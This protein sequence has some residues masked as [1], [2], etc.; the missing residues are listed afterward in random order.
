MRK[1]LEIENIE[2]MRRKEGIDDVELHLEIL[3]L[4][5]GDFVKVSLVTAATSCEPRLVQITSIRGSAFRGKLAS[6]QASVGSSKR[7]LRTSIDFTKDH[8]HS[9][10]HKASPH[11]S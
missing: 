7:W 9:I 11:E 8:I 6:S 4:K 2:E 1:P 3:G 5:V 10:P